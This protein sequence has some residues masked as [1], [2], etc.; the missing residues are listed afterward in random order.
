MVIKT[1][2]ICGKEFDAKGSDKCCSSEC[3]KENKRKNKKEWR[4]ANPEKQREYNR[5]WREANPEKKRKT[6]RKWR[7]ANPD[8]E[9][10]RYEANPEYRREFNRK[11]REENPEYRKEYYKI[12]RNELIEKDYIR[13]QNIISELCEQYSGDLERIL[14]NIPSRWHV[15]EAKMR[16]WF[17]ESYV[18]GILAKIESTPVCEVTGEK[19]N[20]VIHHLYSF[21][22]HPELGNDT[23]NMVR[24]TSA[25]HNE[26][27][28]IYGRGNNTCE[29]WNEFV[30]NLDV[31]RGD[32]I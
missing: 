27:H 24:I 7:E 1:C 23:A 18:D 28:K 2:K 8:Y 26:F 20:L 21:N 22:T 14:K 29:Q 12:H 16:V 6:N 31:K 3:S 15:R 11:W 13:M 17:G 5:K 30:E 10:K 19:D 4:K 32:L 9:K 25:V